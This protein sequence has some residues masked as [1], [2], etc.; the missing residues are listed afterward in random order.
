M[1]KYS[2]TTGPFCPEHFQPLAPLPVFAAVV[3]LHTRGQWDRPL[4]PLHTA[5][6][7]APLQITLRT[8]K[9][10]TFHSIKSHASVG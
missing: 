4:E 9:G 7:A 6:H 8:A 1:P 3:T 2:R 5:S 10:L